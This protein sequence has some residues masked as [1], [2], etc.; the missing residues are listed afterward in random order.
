MALRPTL[1]I[2]LAVFAAVFLGA[3][4]GQAWAQ[5]ESAAGA[6]YVGHEQCQTCHPD[7]LAK[8]AETRMGK[9]FLR[10]PRDELEKWAC[11]SC[12]GPGS[13]HVKNP[14]DPKTILRFGKQSPA[15]VDA[16]NRA[17][18]QCHEKGMQ[19]YW[20]GS[21]HEARG[22]A[23]MN[24]HK[25][26]EKT[27]DRS[28]LVSEEE[29]TPFYARRAAS[30]VC[31][32]CHLQRRAQLLRSSHM[33]LWEGKMTCTDCHNPHGTTTPALL[34][35]NSVNENCYKCHAEKRGP[36]LW[37]HPPVREDCL[38]CHD[39]HGS[40]QANLLKVK[41][42]RLCQQCHIETRHPTQ[43]FSPT[44]RFVF[45]RSCTNCHPQIH[46]SNHPS[47]AQFQR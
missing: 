29:K 22:L 4:A 38:N 46:G 39:P 10:G 12:H 36:F 21:P 43:P 27:S 47:G 2:P 15:A 30:E 28:Q 25:V 1:L 8:F 44:A 33:P 19:T 13:A 18:L 20:T 32:Q 23:C 7:Q 31:F 45:N 40:V 14:T 6:A 34:I 41:L 42:P 9:I 24:C 16:Q 5:V 17:C 35:E 3:L 37:E 26:M 11:E